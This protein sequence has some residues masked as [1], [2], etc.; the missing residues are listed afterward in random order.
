MS[1]HSSSETIH[2]R[3]CRFPTNSPT[4]TRTES[5]MINNFC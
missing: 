3:D 5:H 2:G 4:T 1:D